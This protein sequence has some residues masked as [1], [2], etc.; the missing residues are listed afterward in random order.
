[1]FCVA[2]EKYCAAIGGV[3]I[4]I[5][6][7][8]NNDET[9]KNVLELQETSY[10][11]EAKIIDFYE[12]PPLKDTVDSIRTCEENFY[13]YFIDGILAGIV[14]YKTIKNIIDIHRVAVHPCFFRRGISEKLLSFVEKLETDINKV[15]VCTGKENIPAVCLYLK[16]GYKKTKDIEISNNI[17]ITKFEKIL[18]VNYVTNECTILTKTL[19]S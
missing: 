5:K 13:G 14:S 11:I 1:M 15:V 3:F 12:L 7:N 6:L 8:L 10:K 9:L 2:T 16:N 17:Y 18:Y 19:H 4:I